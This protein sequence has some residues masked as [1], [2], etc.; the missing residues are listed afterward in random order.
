MQLLNWGSHL[1]LFDFQEVLWD[2]IFSSWTT[3]LPLIV[4]AVEELMET[5]DIESMDWLAKS[6]DLNLIEHER[7]FFG[8]RVAARHPPPDRDSAAA[9]GYTTRMGYD[10]STAR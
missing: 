10:A 4:L 6:L 2:L 8:R 7:K 1:L 3:T 5:E 9:I